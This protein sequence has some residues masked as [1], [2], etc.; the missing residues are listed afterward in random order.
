MAGV[1]ADKSLPDIGV[2]ANLALGVVKVIGE[3]RLVVETKDGVLDA[4]IA[5]ATVFR[6]MTPANPSP[7]DAIE[8]RPVDVSVGD[9]VL[10]VGWVSEDRSS[11]VTSAVYLV[12]DM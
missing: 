1:S 12:K 8:S 7:K 11:I 9:L 2:R 6:R 5:P 4:V 3:Q 10:L